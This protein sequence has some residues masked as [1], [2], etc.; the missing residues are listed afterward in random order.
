MPEN[1]LSQKNSIIGVAI[2]LVVLGGGYYWYSSSQNSSAISSV[3]SKVDPSLFT[4][5]DVA[6]FYEAKDKIKLKDLS[7][8]KKSSYTKLKD[9]TVE[10]P[11]VQPTGRDNPFAPYYVAP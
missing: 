1:I 2:L 10:I 11:L 7:F 3:P 6:D 5:T 4:N 8:M 9:N